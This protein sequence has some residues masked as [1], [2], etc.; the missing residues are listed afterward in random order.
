MK[1][2]EKLVGIKETFFETDYALLRC[3]LNCAFEDDNCSPLEF[4]RSMSIPKKKDEVTRNAIIYFLESNDRICPFI[5]SLLINLRNPNDSKK[6][7][8]NCFFICF[9]FSTV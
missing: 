7:K 2:K 8:K 5:E 4:S 6:K 9:F 3:L 1:K